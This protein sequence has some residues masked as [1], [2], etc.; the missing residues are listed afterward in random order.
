M[1]NDLTPLINVIYKRYKEYKHLDDFR[2]GIISKAMKNYKLSTV[3]TL[4]QLIKAA[5]NAGD[6]G[7]VT[8]LLAIKDSENKRVALVE[9]IEEVANLLYNYFINSDEAYEFLIPD[10]LEESEEDEEYYNDIKDCYEEIEVNV[11]IDSITVNELPQCGMLVIY[12]CGFP[13]FYDGNPFKISKDMLKELTKGSA[14]SS[15]NLAGNSDIYDIGDVEDYW[16][17]DYEEGPYYDEDEE[18]F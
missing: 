6:I 7:L 4:S 12:D 1:S 10:F 14:K 16:E 17:D 3:S 15:I 18:E 13:V 11:G 9:S 8:S 5:M 2:K